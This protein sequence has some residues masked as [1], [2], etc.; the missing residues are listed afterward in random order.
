MSQIDEDLKLITRIDEFGR[1]LTSR[2]RDLVESC[3][4]QL[5]RGEPLSD[6]RRR[7]ALDIDERRVG[8]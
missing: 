6:A 2:E 1:G 4:A 7:W 3:L 5:A 8:A